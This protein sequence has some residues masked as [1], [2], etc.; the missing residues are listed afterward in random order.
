MGPVAKRRVSSLLAAAKVLSAVLSRRIIQRFA[1]NDLVLHAITE[2][3]LIADAAIA[4]RIGF[5]G[6]DLDRIRHV[7]GYF[8]FHRN[9]GIK[10]I[11]GSLCSCLCHSH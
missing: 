2:W 10:K 8:W 3:L 1:I 7:F 6:D 11:R 5:T 4:P 9:S